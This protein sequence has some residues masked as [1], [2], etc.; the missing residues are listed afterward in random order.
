MHFSLENPGI[1]TIEMIL[2]HFK[3]EKTLTALSF[4]IEESILACVICHEKHNCL[5]K[6]IHVKKEKKYK[7]GISEL[8]EVSIT[9]CLR[10]QM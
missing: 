7:N 9:G 2:D 4:I 6:D 3:E 5:K 10:V 8:C 1:E